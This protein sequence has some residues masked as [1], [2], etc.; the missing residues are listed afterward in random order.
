MRDLLFDELSLLSEEERNKINSISIALNND[1][2]GTEIGLLIINSNDGVDPHTAGVAHYNRIELGDAGKDNGV[3][4]IFAIG[5]RH[6]ELIPG[7][8]YNELFNK[9]ASVSLLKSVVIPH[10]KAGRQGDGMIAGMQAIA[11]RIKDFELSDGQ[12]P[13]SQEISSVSPQNKKNGSWFWPVMIGGFLI[14]LVGSIIGYIQSH[15]CPQCKGWVAITHKTITSATYTSEGTGWETKDCTKCSYHEESTYRIPK[16]EERTSS[17]NDDDDDRS[18]G[19][20]SSDGDGGGG[21]DW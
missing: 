20:G 1:I 12:I 13:I 4:L 7:R 9:D 18:S 14:V 19:G 2:P 6:V 5:D 17:S 16:L 21:A 11:Q 15:K 3:L 8:R 10:M